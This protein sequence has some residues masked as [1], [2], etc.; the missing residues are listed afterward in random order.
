MKL[1]LLAVCVIGFVACYEVVP[2]A[3]ALRPRGDVR[4]SPLPSLSAY[5]PFAKSLRPASTGIRRAPAVVTLPAQKA[6]R[7]VKR[8]P[9][10]PLPMT[11]PLL[12]PLLPLPQF[13][14]VPVPVLSAEG[15]PTLPTLAPHTFPTFTPIPGMPTMPALTMPPSFQRLLGITTTTMKPAEKAMETVQTEESDNDTTSEARAHSAPTYSK[16][17]NTIRSRLSKFVRGSEK[18][19]T[20][21]EDN[22]DWIVP[23][24]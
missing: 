6:N 1:L 23:F 3:S 18:K 15:L 4:R 12:P 24:H 13:I 22:A 16:D 10:K 19:V 7:S 17:L 20:K 21:A 11:L 9:A 2:R 8:A 5:A 14:P